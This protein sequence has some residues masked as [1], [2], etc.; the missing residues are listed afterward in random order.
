MSNR[1]YLGSGWWGLVSGTRKLATVTLDC[2]ILSLQRCPP[3][4]DLQV[5]TFSDTTIVTL[6]FPDVLTNAVGLSVLIEN[7][8]RVLPDRADKVV[9]IAQHDPLDAVGTGGGKSEAVDNQVLTAYKLTGWQKSLFGIRTALN[10]F[11]DPKME[12]RTIFLP[13]DSL[14][15]V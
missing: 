3:P 8:S 9:A 1:N 6:N 13:R 2:R 15:A 4:Q 11:L 7:W 12:T 5:F 10:I 14:S